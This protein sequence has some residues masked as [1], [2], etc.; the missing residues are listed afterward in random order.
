MNCAL[1]RIPPASRI[2]RFLTTGRQAPCNERRPK[3]HEDEVRHR[4]I[5]VLSKGKMR[6]SLLTRLGDAC[7]AP[8]LLATLL[9]P[10]REPRHIF[11]VRKYCTTTSA[12]ASK[13]R[14]KPLNQWM[15]S[16]RRN[17]YRATHT[18]YVPS[19]INGCRVTEASSPLRIQRCQ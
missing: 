18:A 17:G 2:A 15:A 7:Q 3:H 6:R 10:L 13:H 14:L 12:R 19:D 11:A 8:T 4:S 1:R 5:V 16:R 9:I